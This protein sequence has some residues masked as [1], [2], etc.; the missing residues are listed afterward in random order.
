MNRLIVA[1][2]VL[3]VGLFLRRKFVLAP[4]REA[5]LV[6]ARRKRWR[7]GPRQKPDSENAQFDRRVPVRQHE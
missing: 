6:A 5:A 2:L 3:A 4:R 1:T 7:Q